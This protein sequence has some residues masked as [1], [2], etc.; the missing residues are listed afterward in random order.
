VTVTAGVI[1]ALREKWDS[2]IRKMMG[3]VR[4]LL[5]LSTIAIATACSEL[6]NR[7]TPCGGVRSVDAT[8]TLPDTGLGAGGKANITFSESQPGRSLDET[9][10]IVWTFP[11]TNASFPG[12]PPRV[13][14]LTDDGRVFLD[15]EANPAYQGSWYARA[16]IPDTA[17]RDEIVAAF[18]NGRVSVEFST[19]QPTQKTR[20]VPTIAFAG[21][22]PIVICR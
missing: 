7:G 9:S 2:R 3:R 21:R 11:P 4:S 14:I 12:N 8:A 19:S 15:V 17:V 10:L 6:L 13:R 5:L 18:Q 1:F 22:T 20:V 16:P